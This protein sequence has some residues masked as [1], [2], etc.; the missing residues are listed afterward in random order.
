MKKILAWLVFIITVAITYGQDEVA[1]LVNEGIKLHDDRKYEEALIKYDSALH[2]SKNHYL[3]NYE[4]SYTLMAMKRYDECITISR[5]LLAL[6]PKNINSKAVYVNLGSAL[7][8]KG[9]ETEALKEFSKGIEEYPDFYLLYFNRGITYNKM[10]KDTE[11]QA[12]LQNA[13]RCRPLHPGSHLFLGRLMMDKNRVPAIFSFFT[14]LLAEP[15]S[16]RSKDQYNQME[17]LFMKGISESKGG[18]GATVIG[19]ESLL[20]DRKKKLAE[21]DFSSLDVFLSLAGALDKDDKYKNQ[22][23]AERLHRKTGDLITMIKEQKK[24]G[25]GF[26]WDFYVP[27]LSDLKANDHLLTAS[28]IASLQ[29]ADEKV[30]KWLEDNR[31]KI[32]AFYKWMEN[33]KWNTGK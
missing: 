12:D 22:N 3:A 10:E 8:D 14:F 32:D 7:D 20:T 33:Y 2:I 19:I 21:N 16:A 24:T 30:N 29:S 9:E 28:Y 18:T 23:P 1:R 6:E 5:F 4:K 26:Y 15:E 17:S 25:E 27:F 31:P 11:A 13:L